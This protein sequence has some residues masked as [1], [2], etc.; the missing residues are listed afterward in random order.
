MQRFSARI[1]IVTAMKAVFDSARLAQILGGDKYISDAK[2]R[3]W[4]ENRADLVGLKAYVREYESEKYD[5]IFVCKSEK[6]E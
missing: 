6:A 3:Q 4:N 5:N 2:V 1:E